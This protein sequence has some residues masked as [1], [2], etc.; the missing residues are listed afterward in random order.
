M[1]VTMLRSSPRN[2]IYQRRFTD[3]WSANNCKFWKVWNIF[4]V[5]FIK[6]LYYIVQQIACTAPINC[7]DWVILPSPS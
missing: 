6:Y 5:I 7:R 4:D 3:I 2:D 1:G